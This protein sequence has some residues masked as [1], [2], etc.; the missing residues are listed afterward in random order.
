MT[1]NSFRCCQCPVVTARLTKWRSDLTKVWSTAQQSWNEHS[2]N[3]VRVSNT[4][5]RQRCSYCNENMWPISALHFPENSSFLRRSIYGPIPSSPHYT[6]KNSFAVPSK[7]PTF[8][9]KVAWWK[10]WAQQ[11]R[12]C[13]SC[14]TP[15]PGQT[16]RIQV[17]PNIGIALLPKAT[18]A[19]DLW[20]IQKSSCW[21]MNHNNAQHCII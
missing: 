14:T 6:T 18:I 16:K 4:I 11:G 8:V 9:H 2:W 7:S 12:W 21:D 1:K 15:L 19:R 17:K 20:Q 13:R 10:S 3:Y 5:G